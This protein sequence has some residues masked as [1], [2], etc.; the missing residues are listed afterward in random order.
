MK[1][2]GANWVIGDKFYGRE[3]DIEAMMERVKDKNHTLITA[4]RRMGKT[5]LV[6]ELLR[7]FDVQGGVQTVFVDLEAAQSA[8]DAITEMAAESLSIKDA[9]HGIKSG[10][11]NAF[12]KGF[13]QVDE[14]NLLGLKIKLRTGIDA[15]NWQ[16]KGNE[17]FSALAKSDQPVVI[18]VD[19]FP[20]LINRLL[21]GTN[22]QITSERKQATDEFM[23]WLRKN[24]QSYQ[25]RITLILLGSIGLEPVLRQAGLSATANIYA[26]YDLKPWDKTT[27]ANCLAK[28][29]KSYNVDLSQKI[30]EDMCRRLRWMVPHHI[31]QFFDLLHNHIQRN[32]RLVATLED[33]K[34]VYDNEMLG[35]RGQANLDHY[36]QRLKSALGGDGYTIALD[37]LTEAAVND[38]ELTNYDVAQFRELYEKIKGVDQGTMNFVLHLLVHDGYLDRSESGY[39]FLSGLLQDWWKLHHGGNFNP[40]KIRTD[41]W[42]QKT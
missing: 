40:I 7:V 29:A 17:I 36:E 16:Q 39:M 14:I 24:A 8:E 35:P 27:A 38:G 19:E 9:Q 30:R 42:A 25:D 6:R 15:G 11:A 32:Q 21:K 31:Q 10:F 4:Q 5:S 18:A 3:T 37:L 1:K 26:P 22:Y 23:S 34:T 2:S 13:E 28:L 41:Q 33:V 20:I 12:K